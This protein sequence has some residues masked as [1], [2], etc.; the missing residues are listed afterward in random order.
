MA[1][2]NIVVLI[3]DLL[4]QLTRPLLRLQTSWEAAPLDVNDRSGR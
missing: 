1:V 4:V 3:A 2:V